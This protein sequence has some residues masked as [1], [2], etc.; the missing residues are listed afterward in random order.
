MP[1]HGQFFI[2]RDNVYLALVQPEPCKVR[3]D[4]GTHRGRIFAHAAREHDGIDT[5]QGRHE[6]TGKPI[7]PLAPAFHP[8]GFTDTAKVDKWFRRNCN[9]VLSRECTAVEKADVLA[10]LNALKP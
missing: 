7:S 9:D 8:R 6:S 1:R 5:T 3:H 4:P 10:Y 2:G